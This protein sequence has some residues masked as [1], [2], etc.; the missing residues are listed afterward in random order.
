MSAIILIILPFV[1]GG[2]VGIVNRDYLRPLIET[3]IGN[4]MLALAAVLMIVGI[5]WMRAIIR[6]DK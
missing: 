4:A 5:F 2:M 3:R 6:V 1:I